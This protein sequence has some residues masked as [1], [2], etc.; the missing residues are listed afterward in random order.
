MSLVAP[1]LQWFFT[2]RLTTQR[3]ASQHT[4]A[5]YRD[6]CRLLLRIHARPNRQATVSVGLGRPRRR[7]RHCVPRAPRN[8]SRQ[9]PTHPQRPADRDQ[10]TV[11]LRL[12]AAPRA[13]HLDR[14]GVGHP[15]EAIRQG[16]RGLPRR[17]RGGRAVGGAEPSHL[18]RP[19]RLRADGPGHPDRPAHLRAARPQPRRHCARDRWAR[20]LRRQG[21]QTAVR[22]DDRPSQINRR[23][24]AARTRRETHPIP[25]SSPAPGAASVS[26]PSN[27]G[28]RCTPKP[29]QRNAPRYEENT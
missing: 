16:D 4:I 23:S 10:V 15:T 21:P 27:D 2:D 22:P 8:R 26:T 28:S 1:T 6:T 7:R 18:G 25:S 29:Q 14:A 13:R 3:Q 9:W 12:A 11:R 17:R 19:A 24:L 5:S 20:P